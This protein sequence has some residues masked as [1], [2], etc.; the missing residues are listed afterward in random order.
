[1]RVH[2]LAKKINVPSKKLIDGLRQLGVDIKSH[3]SVL[4]E[5]TIQMVLTALDDEKR[6]SAEPAK[7]KPVPETKISAVSKPVPK[8]ARKEPQKKTET[9]EKAPEIKPVKKEISKETKKKEEIQE[10]KNVLKITGDFIVVSELANKLNKEPSEVIKK[11]IDFGVMAAINQRIDLDTAGTI[12]AE[13]GFEIESAPLFG[14]E[15]VI[16]EEKE[17]PSKLRPRA[18][19][20]TIMGHVDHGKTKLLDAIRKTNVVDQES[21]GITQHI[22]AYHVKLDKGT[23]VFLDTPGHEAFTAMRARGAKVTDIVV[24][25]VAADDGVMPQ[26]KEAVDHAKAA[27]VPIIVA[28]NKIDKK[29]ANPM[30]V[31]QQ[32]SDYGLS[33]EEWGGKTIFVEVSALMKKGISDLL[34]MILLQA[35]MLELKANPDRPAKGTIVEASMDK[36]RGVMATVLIQQGILHIGDPFISGHCFGK[37]KAMVD[38]WGKRLKEAGPSSPVQIMGISELPQAGDLF[39]VVNDEKTARQIGIK[40]REMDRERGLGEKGHIKLGDVYSKIQQGDMK[41]LNIII[42][43]DV[44]GSIEALQGTLEQLSTSKVKLNIIHSGVGAITE[45]DVLLASASNAIIIGFT[46]RPEPKVNE[47]A[48]REGIDIRLYRIIYDVIDDVRKA[49]TGLLEPKFKEVILGRAEI[50]EV[51][52]IPKI[53]NI[54][55]I[56][57]TDGKVTRSSFVRLVR[58]SVVVFEGKISSLRRF[59]EDAKEVA[60]GYECGLGIENYNDIKQNDILEFY[61]KETVVQEL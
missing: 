29:E 27:N 15:I 51:F 13:Y 54:A 46:V 6:K 1:M 41:G 48:A 20:V 31:K 18:P 23:I 42:K 44:Q 50:R 30:R 34:E 26:T 10:K 19:I 11:L 22:G 37:I 5:D 58:D 21:G 8:S 60:A 49:M 12:A 36:K 3:M 17:D 24:L 25:V 2:E 43:A 33:P 32:L 52:R 56:Y 61:I 59:K 45:S 14:E 16:K 35:E 47:L 28:I 9:E 40:R 38:D 39:Y 57:I 53:G 7:L 4:S 55:G